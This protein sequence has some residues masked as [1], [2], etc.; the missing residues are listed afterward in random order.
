VHAIVLA[1]GP[2]P[3][4]AALDRSWPGWDARVELVVGADSGA[5]AAASLGLRLDL[6]VG[7]FDSLRARDVERLERDGVELRASPP[8]KDETDTELAVLAA[9]ARDADRI[10]I[11]GALGGSRVDHE[12]ANV[13]LLAHP[14]LG[15]R[16]VHVLDRR[17]RTSL[18]RAPGPD[19]AAVLRELPGAP[20]S[21]VSLLPLDG[22]VSGIK[23][24]QFLYPLT[25]EPLPLGPARGLSN[26]RIGDGQSSSVSVR[27]GRL[28]VIELSRDLR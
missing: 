21:T 25:D 28:L 7:D 13:A 14:A 11:L 17:S 12:L 9:V 3:E 1:G 6:V 10:T 2:A 26:V 23:T 5:L 19:G 15:G 27:R 24:E 18:I 20:G 8:A 16:T 4:R 22:D